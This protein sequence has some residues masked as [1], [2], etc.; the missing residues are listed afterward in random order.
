[1]AAWDI[2]SYFSLSRKKRW[3][4]VK[5]VRRHYD[6]LCV[7][8]PKEKRQEHDAAKL[9]RLNAARAAEI[10]R[11]LNR[12]AKY[13]EF[14]QIVPCTTV[15]ELE[16]LAAAHPDKSAFAKALCDQIRV[17]HK[18]FGI[19]QKDLPPIGDDTDD[20]AAARLGRVL[21]DIV[22]VPL[23]VK[24]PPPYPYP[25]RPQHAAPTDRAV[26]LDIQHLTLVSEA[27]SQLMAMTTLSVF[28]VPRERARRSTRPVAK[29]PRRDASPQDKALSWEVFTEESVEWK[30]LS[31][32]WSELEKQVFTSLLY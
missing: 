23:P 21:R 15:T 4:L 1:V 24:P 8:A 3:G 16:A 30:V 20:N 17:R 27:W 19:K 9:E 6:D 18:V 10:T 14:N 22:V 26:I 25:V 12:A 11:C 28:R 5:D 31:P 7:L 29:K 13:A 32:M 2:T